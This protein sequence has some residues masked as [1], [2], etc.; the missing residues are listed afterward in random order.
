[1]GDIV[2]FILA[3]L[4]FFINSGYVTKNVT[5]CSSEEDSRYQQQQQQQQDALLEDNDDDDQGIEFTARPKGGEEATIVGALD[6]NARSPNLS[7]YVSEKE[8]L[9][10]L[11][12]AFI[13]KV[14][15]SVRS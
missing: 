14:P 15:T 5:S 7:E 8:V 6:E 3:C 13:L 12:M 11:K 4:T 1:M 2:T 10:I 9:E